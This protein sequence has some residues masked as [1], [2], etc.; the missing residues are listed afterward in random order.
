[1]RFCCCENPG[2]PSTG[3]NRSIVKLRK[4]IDAR[5]EERF[6]KGV[7]KALATPP[8]PYTPKPKAKPS[9]GRAK[10]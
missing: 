7:K 4:L 9:G 2:F 1:M 5:H 3:R 10:K 6:M 8:K